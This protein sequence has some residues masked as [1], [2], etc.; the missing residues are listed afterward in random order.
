[1]EPRGRDAAPRRQP[2]HPHPGGRPARTTAGGGGGDAR[3]VAILLL[4]LLQDALGGALGGE[5]GGVEWGV[6]APDRRRQPL[7]AVL[8][9]LLLLLLPA[10]GDLVRRLLLLLHGDLAHALPPLGV[11]PVLVLQVGL[12]LM[13]LQCPPRSPTQTHTQKNATRRSKSQAG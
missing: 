11:H 1:M 7:P 5:R 10:H 12:A 3:L 4:L 8:L 9:L 6:R 13:S 2:P